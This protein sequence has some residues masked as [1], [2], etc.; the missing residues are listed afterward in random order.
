MCYVACILYHL[1]RRG[2]SGPCADI[3][4]CRL[5][6][7]RWWFGTHSSFSSALFF[8]ASFIH[9]RNYVSRPY[10]EIALGD[11]VKLVR[12]RSVDI[13]IQMEEGIPE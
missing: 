1:E 2:I 3:C 7:Q 11:K 9:C 4:G 8:L 6:G 13:D 12:S 10:T 5:S